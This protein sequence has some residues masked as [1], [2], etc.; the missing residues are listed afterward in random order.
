MPLKFV[1]HR[2]LDNVPVCERALKLWDNIAAYVE[3]AEAGKLTSPRT[4]PMKS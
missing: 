3:A 1:S 2:W 4:S